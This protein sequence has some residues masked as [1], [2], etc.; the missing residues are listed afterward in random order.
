M[1]KE[2]TREDVEREMAKISQAIFDLEVDANYHY[3]KH[4]ELCTVKAE[5]ESMLEHLTDYF[6]LRF[7]DAKSGADPYG[8]EP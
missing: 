7:P 8:E 4:R 1:S 6:I 2:L 5:K 3:D